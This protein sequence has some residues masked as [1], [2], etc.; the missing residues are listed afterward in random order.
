MIQE[1]AAALMASLR[2][3]T[4][5][6]AAAWQHGQPD[7]EQLRPALRQYRSFIGVLLHR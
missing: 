7:T 6:L 5:E 2:D 3:R 1:I 4:T